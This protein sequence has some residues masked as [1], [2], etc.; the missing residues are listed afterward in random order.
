VEGGQKMIHLGETAKSMHNEPWVWL[1]LGTLFLVLGLIL[2]IRPR[3]TNATLNKVLQAGFP[4]PAPDLPVGLRIA[5][6]CLFLVGAAIFLSAAL[7]TW[8]G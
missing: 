8:L 4:F 1:F 7:F 3:K 6:G 5:S 2:V